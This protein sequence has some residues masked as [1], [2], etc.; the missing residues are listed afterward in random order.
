MWVVLFCVLEQPR[1]Q[2]SSESRVMRAKEDLEQLLRKVVHCRAFMGL[3]Q[4]I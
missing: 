4:K 3:W 1:I 2:I